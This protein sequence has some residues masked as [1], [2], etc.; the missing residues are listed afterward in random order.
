MFETA[1]LAETQLFFSTP[2]VPATVQLLVALT[3]PLTLNIEHIFFA[4][5]FVVPFVANN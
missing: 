3:A 5:I 2:D 4:G 1:G